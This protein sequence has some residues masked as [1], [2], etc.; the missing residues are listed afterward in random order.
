MSKLLSLSFNEEENICLENF[1][2][3]DMFT[4]TSLSIKCIDFLIMKYLNFH[5][6]EKA[7]ELDMKHRLFIIF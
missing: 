6:I 2:M 3:K 4:V 7:F 5:K 1:L